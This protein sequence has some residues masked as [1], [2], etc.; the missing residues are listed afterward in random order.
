[1]AGSIVDVMDHPVT[2]III[3]V[4]CSDCRIVIL[5]RE[6]RSSPIAPDAPVCIE[7]AGKPPVVGQLERDGHPA[8]LARETAWGIG[9]VHLGNAFHL[10]YLLSPSP[11]TARHAFARSRADSRDN[12][13]H[14]VVS[15]PL[16]DH[17]FNKDQRVSSGVRNA[18]ILPV[19]TILAGTM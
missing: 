6:F 14:V 11:G 10:S 17:G 1:M 16:N 2:G 12:D 19:D 3:G 4:I 7:M 8:I 13:I 18:P 9:F 15:M 5:A